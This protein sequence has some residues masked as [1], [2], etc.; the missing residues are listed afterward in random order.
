[1]DKER[2]DSKGVAQKKERDVH[3]LQIKIKE[4]SAKLTGVHTSYHPKE[5]CSF[6]GNGSLTSRTSPPN[7]GL[8]LKLT[9]P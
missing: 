3:G 5:W 9:W 8:L 1:M 7:H 6:T 2:K 4:V